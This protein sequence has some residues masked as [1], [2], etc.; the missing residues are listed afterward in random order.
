MLTEGSNWEVLTAHPSLVPF[1]LV[2]LKGWV[3]FIHSLQFF[4]DPH[5][6]SNGKPPAE[7]LCEKLVWVVSGQVEKGK[8]TEKRENFKSF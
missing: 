4:T 5:F 1:S 8:L 3:L 7:V 2:A 6:S